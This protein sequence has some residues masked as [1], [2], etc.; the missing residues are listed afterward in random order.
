MTSNLDILIVED[1]PSSADQLADMLRDLGYN[2]T[3]ICHS[4]EEAVAALRHTVFDL[5]FLDINLEGSTLDGIDLA[6][7][8]QSQ[9]QFPVVFTTS[10]SSRSHLERAALVDHFDYL[11]KPFSSRQL[12]ASLVRAFATWT[13]PASHSPNDRIYIKGPDRFYRCIRIDDLI[14][15]RA[16]GSRVLVF[17]AQKSTSSNA[18]KTHV[19]SSSL[20]SF[21][22]QFT[23]PD[24]LRVHRSYAVNINHV[25]ARTERELL[26]SNQQFIPVSNS[27][28]AAL[29]L[30]LPLLRSK[31]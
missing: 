30:R 15:A 9:Q 16:D 25:I 8:I 31:K 21:L 2:H 3:T 17:E 20:D 4:D 5:A 13:D 28:K 6:R 18:A 1:Q 11:V 27:F 12:F 7:K 22:Q 26:L 19:N 24:L 10:F 14:Y 29:Q 23:H